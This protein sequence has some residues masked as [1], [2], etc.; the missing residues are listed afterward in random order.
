M[1]WGRRRTSAA[2]R[3]SPTILQHAAR[4]LAATYV[5]N[6]LCALRSFINARC[7]G[8]ELYG[9]WGSLTFYMSFGY[10]LHGGV[11][12]AMI[13]EIPAHR[14]SGHS[15]RARESAQVAFTV[16]AAVLSAAAAVFWL[17]AWR[18]PDGTAPIIRWGWIAAGFVVLMEV[19]DDFEQT[20]TRVEERY[21]RLNTALVLTAGMSLALT[22]WLVASYGLAGF[23]IVA[24]ATPALSLWY[25]HRN[26][27]YSWRW[28]WR[29]D[30]VR[31]ML[32]VGWP[33]LAMVV[34]FE[35][36]KWVNQGLILGFIGLEALG[37]YGLGLMVM[38]VCFFFPEVL[39]SVVE[40][41]V[42][43]DFANSRDPS[44]LRDHLWVPLRTMAL[45]MPCGLA[46]LDLLLPPILHHWLP[47]YVPGLPAIR[48]LVWSSLLM[49]LAVS[50]KSCLVALGHQRRV[51]PIYGAAVV[52]NVLLGLWVVQA[53]WGLTGVALA[54]LAG[55][56]VCSGGLLISVFRRMGWS[57][58]DT[59][60]RTAWLYIPC[61]AMAVLTVWLP[62][63][64]HHARPAIPSAWITAVIAVSLAV[65]GTAVA[66][67][68]LKREPWLLRCIPEPSVQP[69]PLVSS[70]ALA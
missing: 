64:I 20:I 65:Y 69:D 9:F 4:F 8:P 18:L 24:I 6:V 67:R 47:A 27:S 45:L 5:A 34:V 15:A 7:L 29:G 41:R 51:L 43:A 42:H 48:I 14:A 31:H 12:E 53:G 21:R 36:L 17:V 60:A 26:A 61:A 50:T 22:A 54:R 1:A 39:A 52:V 59:L 58:R 55:Y 70:G 49:G 3:S 57:M 2:Q 66:L 33:V 68:V 30:R 28:A 23:Y 40:P 56:V 35:S 16:F 25:L 63:A 37:Y 46:A 62:E 13:Q 44:E 11:R 10:H 32:S 38:R 19:L